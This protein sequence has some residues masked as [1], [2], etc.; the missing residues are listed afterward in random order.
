MHDLFL[1][2]SENLNKLYDRGADNAAI[3]AVAT[4]NLYSFINSITTPNV[5]SSLRGIAMPKGVYFAAVVSSIFLFFLLCFRRQISE[6]T[7]RIS[8]KLGHIFT[9]DCYSK[10]LVRTPPGIYPSRGGGKKNDFGTEFELWPNISLQR[11]M[12][13]TIKKK[14]IILQVLFYMPPYLVNIGTETAEKGWRVFEYPLNFRL[15]A[16]TL[17]SRQQAN[18]GKLIIIIIIIIIT[19]ATRTIIIML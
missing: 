12:I 9:Y 4:L 1:W 15:T 13:W 3:N 11:N 7:E 2:T 14:R 17:Y 16:W 10:N 8:T 18:F 19:T 6:V 5:I